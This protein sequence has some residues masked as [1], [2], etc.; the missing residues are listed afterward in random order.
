MTGGDLHPAACRERDVKSAV[1]PL[2]LTSDLQILR[3]AAFLAENR[4]RPA[5]DRP[6]LTERLTQFQR[7]TSA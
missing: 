3:L 2:N 1:K 4:L 5:Q 7:D 6:D